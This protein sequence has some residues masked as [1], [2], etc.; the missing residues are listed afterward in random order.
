MN[1]AQEVRP[2]DILYNA[3]AQ[4]LVEFDNIVLIS[5]FNTNEWTRRL[6]FKGSKEYNERVETCYYVFKGLY[7]MGIP[8]DVIHH[9]MEHNDLDRLIHR[10]YYKKK[11]KHYDKF[12]NLGISVNDLARFNLNTV[13]R[14][15]NFKM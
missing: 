15:L 11:S 5:L 2:I 12:C 14:I 6:I 9:H 4:N 7:E 10:E 13:P 1:D 8:A 3:F